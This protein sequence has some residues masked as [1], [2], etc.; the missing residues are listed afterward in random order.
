MYRSVEPRTTGYVLDRV[1]LNNYNH[2]KEFL[3]ASSGCNDARMGIQTKS[4]KTCILVQ[5]CQLATVH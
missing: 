4:H 3:V 5:D 2:F 1:H